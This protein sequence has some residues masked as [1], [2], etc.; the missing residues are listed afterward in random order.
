[1]N[2]LGV[3]TINNLSA[4]IYVLCST[5]L[6]MAGSVCVFKIYDYVR[7]KIFSRILTGYKGQ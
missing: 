3:E 2:L 6:S 5:I 4:V 1:M 7:E